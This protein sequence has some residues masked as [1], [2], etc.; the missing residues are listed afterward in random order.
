MFFGVLNAK[1]IQ[2]SNAIEKVSQLYAAG[3]ITELSQAFETLNP[4]INE[5]MATKLY[6]QGKI[7]IEFAE[8]NQ[9]YQKLTD[10]Y[11]HTEYGQKGLFELAKIALLERQYHKSKEYLLKITP[12]TSERDLLLS[13]TYLKMALFPEAIAAAVDYL[14]GGDEDAKKELAYL[15][16]VE[17]YISNNQHP[18]ALKMLEEMRE[19]NIV[20]NCGALITFKEGYCL[21]SCDEIKEAVGKYRQVITHYPYTEQ[22]YQAEKR[23]YDLTIADKIKASELVVISQ[24]AEDDSEPEDELLPSPKEEAYYVQVNA[25]SDISNAQNHSQH[26]KR[27]GFDNIVIPK[28]VLDSKLYAVAVGPFKDR[29]DAVQSQK[30]IKERLNLDSIIIKH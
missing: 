19:K 12:H 25:F 18:Q 9:H 22:S 1:S 28:T 10:E 13:T 2:V 3:K 17:A 21:E 16:I 8:L 7:A 29:Q 6:F 4:A 30:E 11:A 23:L 24:Q 15:N 14:N 20:V 27:Y 5:E 26:M